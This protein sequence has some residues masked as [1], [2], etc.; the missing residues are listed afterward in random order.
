MHTYERTHLLLSEVFSHLQLIRRHL[1]ETWG[2][3]DTVNTK[4][5]HL[6]INDS[7]PFILHFPS[8]V[9]DWMMAGTKSD[10]VMEKCFTNLTVT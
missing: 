3:S 10:T 1:Y 9:S 4:E 8:L 5:K 2:S 7:F 6:L